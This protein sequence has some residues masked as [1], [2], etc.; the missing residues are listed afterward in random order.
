M[1]LAPRLRKALSVLLIIPL[2]QACAEPRGND[3]LAPSG[4]WTFINYWA[5]WCKPCIKEIPELNELDN[6]DGY[7]VLGVNFDGAQG[8]ELQSQLDTL[9]VAFPTLEEDPGPRF[10]LEKPQVL[11][12][13]LVVTP[14]G[15]L[16]AVLVGPQ[17]AETLIAATEAQEAAVPVKAWPAP[18][19]H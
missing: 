7:R 18:P 2:L 4:A 17:T 15:K 10:A 9:Q 6:V 13:T 3:P 11:P 19:N 1:L 16:H 5:Q 14:Q 12:T 8:E